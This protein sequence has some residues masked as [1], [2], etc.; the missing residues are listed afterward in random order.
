MKIK[1]FAAIFLILLLPALSTAGVGLKPGVQLWVYSMKGDVDSISEAV[2]EHSFDRKVLGR[3]LYH[4]LRRS[5]SVDEKEV[6]EVVRLLLTNGADVNYKSVAGRTP[7]MAAAKRN[8]REL[9]T[10]LMENNADPTLADSTGKTAPSIAKAEGNIGVTYVFDNPPAL[11][12]LAKLTPVESKIVNPDLWLEDRTIVVTYDLV[13]SAPSCTAL[14]G[15]LDGGATYQMVFT[16]VSGDIGVGV[17]PGDDKRVEWQLYDDYPGGLDDYDV[18]IDIV[19][20][21]CP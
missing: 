12:P 2:T 5:K 19:I 9:I 14:I 10:L 1:T 8:S 7:L 16:T 6:L 11:N 17:A 21:E 4:Y 18:L 3:A 15:S 13:G 20:A